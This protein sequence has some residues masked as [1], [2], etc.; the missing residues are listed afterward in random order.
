MDKTFFVLDG[1][2]VRIIKASTEAKARE[3][4]VNKGYSVAYVGTNLP[5]PRRR[6]LGFHGKRR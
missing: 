5:R 3:L 6:G 1:S 2:E 4:A